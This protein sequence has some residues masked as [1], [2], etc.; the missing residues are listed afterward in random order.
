MVA[1]NEKPFSVPTAITLAPATAPL[2]STTLPRRLAVEDWA[3]AVEGQ[4]DRGQTGDDQGKKLGLRFMNSPSAL[5]WN[6]DF[7]NLQNQ[8]AA[9]MARHE[10]SAAAA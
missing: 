9:A 10:A 3:P 5:G 6:P 2:S 1:S 7:L 4:K 8:A